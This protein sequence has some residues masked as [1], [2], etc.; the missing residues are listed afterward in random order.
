MSKFGSRR[1]TA[2]LAAI[3]GM[4]L[5]AGAV[6]AAPPSLL[7]VTWHGEKLLGKLEAKGSNACWLLQR[8]GQLSFIRDQRDRLDSHGRSAV[9]RV[10]TRRFA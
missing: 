5:C 9:P 7:E 2:G 10:F 3:A 8:D 1:V 4:L 6:F